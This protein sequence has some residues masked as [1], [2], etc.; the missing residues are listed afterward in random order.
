M[1]E[2]FSH[3][4]KTSAWRAMMN[5]AES[6]RQA[7]RTELVNA[8]ATAHRQH[9]EKNK[10][11][12]AAIEKLEGEIREVVEDHQRRLAPLSAALNE[13]RQEIW[14]VGNDTDRRVGLATKELER[15]ADPICLEA[16]ERFDAR[17][18]RERNSLRSHT[19][20]RGGKG[21]D[22][23]DIP[24]FFSTGPSIRAYLAA[25]RDAVT[26]ARALR[27]TN[28]THE[29]LVKRIQEIEAALP[30]PDRLVPID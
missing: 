18:E 29:Q 10:K 8:I 6:E 12:R 17:W 2:M 11:A 30:D 4:Q 5:E 16:A 3:F 23:K 26:E 20:G 24:P 14:N 9:E 22:G 7:K 25:L 13:A 28:L 1:L 27:L 19:E 15:T 21:W